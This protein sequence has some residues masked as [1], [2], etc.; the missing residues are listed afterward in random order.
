MDK[1]AQCH[2]W[3][4]EHVCDPLHVLRRSYDPSPSVL[5][6]LE[7]SVQFQEALVAG[8]L[9]EETLTDALAFTAFWM[10]AAALHEGKQSSEFHRN[11]YMLR[12]HSCREVTRL[13]REAWIRDQKPLT[14]FQQGFIP[15]PPPTGP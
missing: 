14:D 1:K 11:G 10:A 4:V 9:H 3:L 6:G 5:G 15:P 13:V 7:F 12:L 2:A 8:A